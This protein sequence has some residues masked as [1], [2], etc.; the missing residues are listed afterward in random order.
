MKQLHT[1]LF[2][3]DDDEDDR[4]FFKEAMKEFSQQVAVTEATNGLVALNKLNLLASLPHVIFLDL[5]MPVMD[6]FAFLTEIKQNCKLQDIP[7]VILSTGSHHEERCYTMGA[8]GY[9]VKP[10]NIPELGKF[11]A[12]VLHTD[13]SAVSRVGI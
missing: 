10:S 12:V 1:D 13:F 9:I 7:V 8:Q 2:L 11:V 6:R 4:F 3:I 5:N